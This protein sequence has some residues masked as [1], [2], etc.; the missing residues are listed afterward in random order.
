[1]PKPRSLALVVGTGLA[2]VAVITAARLTTPGGG[3]DNT[4]SARPSEAE[5]RTVLAR[6]HE[7]AKQA[8]DVLA[9][10]TDTYAPSICINQYNYV[11]GR[12]AVPTDPPKVVESRD[13]GPLRI[14]TVCGVDGLGKTY[15]ADFPVQRDR[16][17]LLAILDVFWDSKT[18]N[19]QPPG[20]PIH[21]SPRPQASFSC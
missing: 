2:A 10:C 1:M 14:L 5:A 16:G 7:R 13:D 4:R 9:F 15:R 18:S 6:T 17:R 20:E 12:A 11:G 3:A 19:N 21:A 8:G